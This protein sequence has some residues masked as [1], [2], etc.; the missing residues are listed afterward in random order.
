M[1]RINHIGEYL[2]YEFGFKVIKLS[3]DG[4]FTCP[5]R[6]GTKGT[7]GCIFCSEGG[8]GE[9]AGTIEQQLALLSE[10]WPSAGGYIAYFQ[11]HTNTYAPADVL[12]EKY[13]NALAYP[14]IVGLA[15]ATRP[16]C[17]PEET[18]DLLEELS[19]KTYLWVELGLQT[20]DDD[21]A[22][23]INRCYPLSDYDD[24]VRRLTERGIRVVTHLILGL[25]GETREIMETSV[26]H[27]TEPVGENPDGTG[28]HIFGMKLHLLNVVKNTALMRDYPGYTPFG[29]PEEYI[30]LVCDMLEIIPADITMHRLTGD[31]PRRLLVA[32]EWSYKK[33]TI[34]N[35]IEKEMRRRGSF[36]GCR[37]K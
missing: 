31:V 8:S 37:L 16:D 5:N 24:A 6:D 20:S 9:L 33:R 26:R 3:I 14:G 23:R 22:M 15:V 35:G 11:S 36:Q 28:R 2:R 34:L 21:T 30:S 19:E 1:Q 25:P 27:V 29:T 17:L 12:R 10:K 32:P 13:E 4:G 7:G 18:L